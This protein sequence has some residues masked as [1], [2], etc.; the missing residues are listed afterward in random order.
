[1]VDDRSILI[2]VMACGCF[3]N[4]PLGMECFL[5]KKDPILQGLPEYFQNFMTL[6]ETTSPNTRTLRD[7]L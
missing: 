4:R 7:E 1:M 6:F 5:S 2:V 3:E